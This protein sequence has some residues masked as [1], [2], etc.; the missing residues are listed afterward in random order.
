MSKSKAKI[1]QVQDVEISVITS[2]KNDYISITDIA[3]TK[4]GDSRAADIIKNWIRNRT[5]LEFLGTWEQLYNPH[6]KVVEFDHFKMHAGLP[7]FVLSPGTWVEKTNAIGIYVKKGKYGGTYAHKDIAFEFCSAINP[8]FKL[9]L[10]KEF[11]RLKEEES[12]RL[13]LE[14]DLQRTIAKINYRIHTDAVREQLIP[15]EI[16]DYHAGLVYASEADLLNVALFSKTAREWREA[17]PDKPG[18]IRDEATLEQLVVLS[19][20]ESIN[21]LLL[22]QGLSQSER[23][24]QLNKVAI[25]QMHSLLDNN[26]IKKL[27]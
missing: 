3:N 17:N 10:I 14:W 9:F 24:I 25:T 19:N 6:F 5:T 18:N 21:A 7:T 15:D 23:L 27:R 22:R 13:Q 16:T 8:V 1:I 2:L 11:Q 26:T 4:E 12:N 20:L